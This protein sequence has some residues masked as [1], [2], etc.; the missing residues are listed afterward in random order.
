MQRLKRD[1]RCN[2]RR[3]LGSLGDVGTHG[4]GSSR[5][6]WRIGTHIARGSAR[7]APVVG[8]KKTAMKKLRSRGAIGFIYLC[9]NKANLPIVSRRETKM[10]NYCREFFFLFFRKKHGWGR[11]MRNYGR[12]SNLSVL[13]FAMYFSVTIQSAPLLSALLF[14]K[15]EQKGELHNCFPGL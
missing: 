7:V 6:S 4:K 3:W 11:E 2:E 1:G 8:K 12:C 10:G 5:V 15:N 13:C 14:L 9:T